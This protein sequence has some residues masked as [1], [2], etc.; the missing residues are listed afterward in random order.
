MVNDNKDHLNEIFHAL[1]DST[2]REMVHMMSQKER[3][4]SELAEPFD[5]SLAAISKHLKVLERANLVERKVNGRTH[6]C[7]LNTE[8]LSQATEW[9]RFYERFWSNRF[10]ILENELLKAKKKEH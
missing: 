7:R 6:L 10:D 2:R 8:S 9:L 4:V 1:A 3:T 5:M